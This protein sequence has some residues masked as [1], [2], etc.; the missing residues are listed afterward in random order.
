MD[1]LN[2][3]IKPMFF[4]YLVAASGSA[5]LTSV[6]SIVDAMM[7]GQYHGPAGNAA[8]AVFNPLW[9]VI[10]S[11][12]LLAGIG[13]SVLFA[14]ERG[15]GDEQTAQAY[16]TL[17]VIYGAVLTTLAMVVI[18][19]FK[20]PLFRFFGADDELL[21]LA[22]RYLAPI[23]FGIPCC[24]FSNILSAY[25]R[26]D[27]NPGL[28]TKAVIIG[29]IF[30]VFGDYFF[31]FALDLGIF[32][33]GLATSTGQCITAFI[34]L[35]HFFTK[36]NTLRFVKPVRAMQK[37][38]EITVTGFSTAITDLAMG[39]IGILFNRQIMNHLGSD[40]LAVYGMITQIAAFAQFLAYGTGQAAQPIISQNFGAGQPERIKECLKY[41][42]FA[43]AGLGL[44]WTALMEFAPTVILRMFMDPTPAVLE[45]A[46]GILR[47]YG[48]SFLLLPFNMFATYY[49]Q[50][51]LK[52]NLS[53]IVSLARGLVISSALVLLLPVL[54]GP[55]SIWYAMLITEI[56]IAAYCGVYMVRC[57]KSLVPDTERAIEAE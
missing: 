22:K 36:K 3:K 46:P 47:A 42:L 48:S 39:I 10:F 51:L 38:G 26:N 20:E 12:G 25:L 56:V 1:L 34:M 49:F 21:D 6:F 13:G 52:P 28:A 33:A 32:G 24:L 54:I 53:M 50:A 40:A 57:T 19:L 5:L 15:K 35:T 55:N 29:G 27:D 18:G 17:A 14:N 8:L 4:R 43:C 37:I 30:N 16:F 31:V 11:F 7:V 44:F 23:Y 45:I 9:S 2:S 41:A